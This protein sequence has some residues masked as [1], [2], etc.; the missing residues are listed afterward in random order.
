MPGSR[1]E[2]PHTGYGKIERDQVSGNGYLA[3]GTRRPHLFLAP[4]KGKGVEGLWKR[5]V[6]QY[7]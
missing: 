2:N 7:G 5:H 4:D 3:P 1:F 6:Y